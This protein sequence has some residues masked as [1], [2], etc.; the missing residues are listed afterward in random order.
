MHYVYITCVMFTQHV[1]CLHNMH[2]VYTTCVMFTQHALYL[3]NMHYVYTTCVMFIQHA[4]CLYNMHYVYN[5]HYVYTY[6]I[7]ILHPQSQCDNIKLKLI[8][9]VYILELA[10]RR[11]ESDR[12]TILCLQ[13]I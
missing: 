10:L 7:Q 5:I 12:T 3:H 11:S 1:L 8:N 6:K 4:L 13:M 2:Y 9:S